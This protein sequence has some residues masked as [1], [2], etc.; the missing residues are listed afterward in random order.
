MTETTAPTSIM[1]R[2]RT[3][4]AE[5]HRAAEHHPFQH[6]LTSGN[7]PAEQFAAYLGQLLLVHRVVERGLRELTAARPAIT[8]IVT[9]EQ[10]QEPYLV[11][12]LR[13]F[14]VD[15]ETIEPTP[16]T[17]AVC[18]RLDAAGKAEPLAYLGHHYVLEG[19]NNGGSFIAKRLSKV[20]GVA[21]GAP[22]LKYFDP[23]G[24]RQ[25]P[26]W[27]EFKSAMSAIPFTAAEADTLERAALE[28]FRG[29][30]DVF[31]GLLPLHAAGD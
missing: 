31:D 13:H 15:P 12:D 16:K 23:Y 10:I 22:G 25:R 30:L 26:L 7:L 27:G 17:R 28:M 4:T 5:L 3:T 9:P 24:D 14:D 21:P 2:L 11:T 8:A 1:D 29:M 6:A 20:Y 19:S 18:E